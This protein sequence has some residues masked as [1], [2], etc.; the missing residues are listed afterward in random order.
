MENKRLE[1][2]IKQVSDNSLLVIYS[3]DLMYKTLDQVFPFEVD[4]SFFYYTALKE[5]TSAIVIKIVNGKYFVK[6]YK[7]I[8]DLEKAKWVGGFLDISDASKIS[9]ID[10]VLDNKTMLLDIYEII[11]S[12]DV[13]N[14]YLASYEKYYKYPF[15]SKI[16]K[17]AQENNL[18]IE[19]LIPYI[20]NQ[21][22]IKDSNEIKDLQKAIDITDLG[23]KEVLKNI[24]KISNEANAQAIF[25]KVVKENLADIAFDTISAS[26]DN[27]TTLHYGKN[28]SKIEK[29]S[30]ILL[31]LGASYNLYNADISRTYPLCGKFSERQKMFYNIVLSTSKKAI[32]MVKPGTN[33]KDIINFAKDNLANELVKIGKIKEKEEITKYYFH[34]VGHPLGLDVHDLGDRDIILKPGMVFT[35]EPGLYMKDEKIGIRIED[36]ILV[37]EKG[38]KVLS[39]NILKEIDEIENYILENKVC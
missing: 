8:T 21:R 14:V 26:G 15:Y 27:A 1:N 39:K 2:L 32:K 30:L 23:L 3:G 31:D 34:S 28:N 19:S 5:E 12:G 10:D 17:V 11:K 6:L 33:Y 35:I 16:E 20:T 38:N 18:N 25:E 36:D 9:K 4:R 24:T 37:T 29:G 22:L 13:K 7:P